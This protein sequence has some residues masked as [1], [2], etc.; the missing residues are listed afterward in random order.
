MELSLPSHLNHF[1]K[2]MQKAEDHMQRE[3]EAAEDA[4]SSLDRIP[5]I[6]SRLKDGEEP[7]RGENFSF[8]DN[9]KEVF[10]ALGPI[11]CQEIEE[12]DWDQ[13][14]RKLSS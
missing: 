12:T 1:P 8:S 10:D 2:A 4:S 13:L 6:L 9:E 14:S 11:T 5:G 3:F 7:D